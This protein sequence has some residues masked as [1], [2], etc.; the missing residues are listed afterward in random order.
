MVA[1]AA[2]PW[3][4]SVPVTADSRSEALV[5][6]GFEHAYNFDHDEA[7]VSF[8]E[9][10]AANP[11]DAAAHR[12][13]AS[14]IWLDLLFTRGAL[15]VD[16]YLG[17]V[18]RANVALRAP[19]AEIEES[20]YF[21]A[22]RALE[23]AEKR[24][25]RSPKDPSALYELGT[26]AGQI[27]A[28]EATVEGKVLAAARTARRTF[29]AHERVLKVEPER[30]D[31]GFLAGLYRYAVS[32]LSLPLRLLAYVAGFGGGRETAIR[33]IEE[34][35]R[36]DGDTR[37]EAS[38]A[39]VFIYNRE[40]RYEDALIVLRGLQ[41]QYPRNRLLWLEEGSTALRAGRLDE[42]AAALDEGFR[43]LE[44]DRRR[45]A[46]GE[47][48]LWKHKRGIL[49]LAQG[50]TAAASEDQKAALELEARDWVR[51]RA[52]TE[53][54]KIADLSGKREAAMAHYGK[55]LALGRT[56]NDPRGV[57]EA[58]RLMQSPYV[59]ES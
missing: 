4:A 32:S 6:R 13:I 8:R 22:R 41:R 43:K 20:F 19:P 23:L 53:I 49:E 27:A 54:G 31:A 24:V 10:I 45:R 2:I 16:D 55:A 44:Q 35:A 34:A 28:Y 39:L 25:R 15:T 58:R 52:H 14:L 29:D 42:A 40:G 21:H 9:A 37:T 51:G 26:A 18:A 46:F 30:K 47:E 3:L 1:F 36:H 17:S 33:M 56:D 48:A 11:E 59:P 12:A 5:R 38:V 50:R 7:M 57:S